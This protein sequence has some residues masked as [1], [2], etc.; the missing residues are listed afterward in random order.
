MDAIKQQIS[1][2]DYLQTQS[3]KPARRISRGR[4]MGLCPLHLD[5]K[6]SFLVDRSKTCSTVMAGVVAAISSRKVKKLKLLEFTDGC[7]MSG[8]FAKVG[9]NGT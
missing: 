8:Q 4:L 7:W 2:L 9:L 3:W 6:P 5:H 1:L